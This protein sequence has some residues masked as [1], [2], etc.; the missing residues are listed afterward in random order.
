MEK[1]WG[2]YVEHFSF[3]IFFCGGFELK[4][5]IGM[6]YLFDLRFLRFSDMSRLHLSNLLDTILFMISAWDISC[7]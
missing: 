3:A 1:I 6:Q 2:R 7:I 5:F 4:R